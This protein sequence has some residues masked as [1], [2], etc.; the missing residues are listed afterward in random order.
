MNYI[1]LKHELIKDFEIKYLIGLM[2]DN[3]GIVTHAAKIAGMDRANFKRLLRKYNI[4]P[5]EFT[6]TKK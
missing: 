2:I 3:N 4:E 1:T 6:V 5:G